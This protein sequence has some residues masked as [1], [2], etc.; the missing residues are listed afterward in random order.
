MRVFKT[1]YGAV[2]YA[3]FFATFVPLSS[4]ALLLVF[5]AWRPIPGSVWNLGGTTGRPG[6]GSVQR[7]R[8]A[9]GAGGHL[10][11]RPLR[12]DAP[13]RAAHAAISP[14]MR[15][16]SPGRNGFSISGRPLAAM[17]S[18]SVAVSMSPVTKTTRAAWS[19][20]R[21]AISPYSARP[22]MP[23]MRM[24]AKITS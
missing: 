10:P 22:S 9:A 3:I 14:T 23:G 1:V 2:A 4:A 8:L 13:A 11:D 15:R 17:N 21:R 5:L 20:Q 19:G 12:A 16:T 18:R 7:G 6:A 24:S